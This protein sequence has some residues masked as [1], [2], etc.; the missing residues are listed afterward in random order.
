MGGA[1]FSNL[2]SPF[3]TPTGVKVDSESWLV[4]EFDVLQKLD[5][6]VAF[7][8][9]TLVVRNGAYTDVPTDWGMLNIH[10]SNK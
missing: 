9:N 3:D 10:W 1:R 2:P 4:L 6:T 7:D 8:P 5:T